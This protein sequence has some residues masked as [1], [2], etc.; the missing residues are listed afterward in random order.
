MG[1]VE[2][3]EAKEDNHDGS[4]DALPCGTL[5]FVLCRACWSARGEAA[6]AGD[7]R[8]FR[9]CQDA[10]PRGHEHLKGAQLLKKCIDTR[11][12]FLRLK[13]QLYLDTWPKDPAELDAAATIVLMWE[14]W[15]FHLVN[16]RNPKR[17]RSWTS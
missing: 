13:T 2:I 6:G 1:R 4:S 11:R 5:L 16:R 12:Y 7:D 15:E 9:R 3:A 17:C 10:R 14:G 8:F